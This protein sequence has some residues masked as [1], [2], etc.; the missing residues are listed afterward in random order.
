M[1]ECFGEIIMMFL[2]FI[3]FGDEISDIVY[4]IISWEDFANIHIRNA[5]LAF[6]A[7]KLLVFF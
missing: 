2:R 7:I 4:L 6:V 3:C 5:S 1:A